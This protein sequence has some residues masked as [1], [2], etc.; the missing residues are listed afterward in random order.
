VSVVLNEA[1]LTT[2]LD[3]EFGAVG[4]DT[5]RRSSNVYDAAYQKIT[6][7][8]TMRTGALINS[9]KAN[10]ARDAFGLR[11]RIYC[12]ADI[13][14]HAVYLELGT[15]PH[16]ITARNNDR[17][18]SAPDNPDPLLSDPVTV[19]HPGNRGSHFLWESL[20]AAAY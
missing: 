3:S 7:T 5:A 4:I 1:A 8:Y 2:L 17:L 12:D 6:S 11:G 20:A 13:A 9:L 19:N 16:E 14:P 18:V 15:V 10:V